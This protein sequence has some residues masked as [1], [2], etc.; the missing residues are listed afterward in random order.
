MEYR[1][2]ISFGKSSYVVSLPKGWVVQNKLKKGDLIYFEENGSNLLI[3]K[4]EDKSTKIEP[5]K[6]I[7]IDR[8]SDLSIQREVCSAYIRNY[9]KIV[10]KGKEVKTRIKSLQ[11]IIQSLIALEIMEQSSEMIVAR[12]FLNM[13]SVSISELLHKMD[14]LT[15]TMFKE[16]ADPSEGDNY[17]N[18]NERDKDVNRLYFLLYRGVLYYLEHPLKILKT[19]KANTSEIL[20]WY[21][22]AFY[23]EAVA[24]EIRRTVRY[25]R[26]LK[27]DQKLLSQIQTLLND[28]ENYYVQSMKAFSNKDAALALELSEKRNLFFDRINQLE[29]VAFKEPSKASSI[30]NTLAHLRILTARIHNIGGIIYTLL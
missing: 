6:L 17:E 10:L 23:I 25:S 4:E 14:L 5:E 13:D 30:Y 12:D 2:L 8:R 3:R 21:F 1:K 24:D 19:V 7:M 28:L 22:A 26:L 16:A 15:R 27:A 9:H 29:M 20:A 18:L 11:R